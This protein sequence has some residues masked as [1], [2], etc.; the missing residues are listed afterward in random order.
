MKGPQSFLK[1]YCYI[2][3]GWQADDYLLLYFKTNL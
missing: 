3:V 1:H 2:L